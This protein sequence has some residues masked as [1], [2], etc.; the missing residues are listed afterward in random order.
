M[1]FSGGNM[2]KAKKEKKKNS[3][4]EELYDWVETFVTAL[5]AVVL[6]FT[7]VLRI[8]AVDGESMMKTL[9]HRDSLV[10]SGLLP[11]KRGDI[12]VFQAI[13]DDYN[14]PLIKRVIAT[15]GQTV[16]IDFNTWTVTV[17]GE[18]LDEPYV[19][20]IEGKQMRSGIIQFPYTVEKGRVFVMGDNRNNSRDSRSFGAIDTRNL[21]GK[22]L[23]RVTPVNKFG[24]VLPVER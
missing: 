6:L 20:Y 4:T 19:N 9:E 7:F 11:A 3:F 16:D 22:V 12:V 18:P 14:A 13:E 21:M 1:C 23:F 10:I 5:V 17:D 8:V 24:K 15:E 2:T